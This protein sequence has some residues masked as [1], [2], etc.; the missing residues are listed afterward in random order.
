MSA[1]TQGIRPLL[2][3]VPGGRRLTR[4]TWTTVLFGLVGLSGI[5]VNQFFLW[6]LVDRFH[7]YYLVAA[8]AASVGSTLWN[9]GLTER[10]V[11][12]SRGS[13]GLAGAGW[14]L[15]SFG[16]LTALTMPLRLGIFY[17]LTSVSGV[18]YLLTNLIA[19]AA[20]F[21]VRYLI[22]DRIIWRNRRAENLS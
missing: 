5:L 7:I 19:I 3:R 16:A 13:A 12:P 1:P 2:E 9:W 15:L 10:M 8:L 14:R 20:M 17:L 6:L 4:L 22:S 21:L 18:N 11:F